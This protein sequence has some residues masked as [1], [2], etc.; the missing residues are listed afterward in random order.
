MGVYNPYDREHVNRVWGT[1]H[2][3]EL[4]SD[5]MKRTK[6]HLENIKPADYIIWIQPGETILAHTNV[7]IL[8]FFCFVLRSTPI[9]TI[10]F[11]MT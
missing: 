5:W 7:M 11:D 1:V 9:N 3:A 2:E 6:V 8:L 10:W 4:A